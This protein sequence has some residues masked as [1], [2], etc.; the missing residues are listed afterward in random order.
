[1]LREGPQF[2]SVFVLLNHGLLIVQKL[3]LS[4][5]E[6]SLWNVIPVGVCVVEVSPSF[7]AHDLPH[8]VNGH[9]ELPSDRRAR[10][11]A[12]SS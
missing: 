4:V 9:P 10:L 2:D 1:M 8:G 3:S 7:A 5:W 12:P 6:Y 11:T